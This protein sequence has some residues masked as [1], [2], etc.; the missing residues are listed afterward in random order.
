MSGI[1]N[2]A[3][4]LRF[5]YGW[6]MQYARGG[7]VSRG[8]FFLLFSFF[9]LLFLKK[10]PLDARGSESVFFYEA[11]TTKYIQAR[12]FFLVLYI[13]CIL[14]IQNTYDSFFF[15]KERDCRI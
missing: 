3:Q 2:K 5:V 15:L 12:S 7:S 10:N 6:H 4:I 9:F 14:T 13:I 8:I 1:G 11:T